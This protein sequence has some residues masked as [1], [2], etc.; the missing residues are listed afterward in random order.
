MGSALLTWV[1]NE[2]AGLVLGI[3]AGAINEYLSER[4]AAAAQRD[5]GR[6]EAERDQAREGERVQA[7]LATEAARRTDPTEAVDALRRGEF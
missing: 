6:L 2:G 4:R 7:D 5:A 1:L 3:L